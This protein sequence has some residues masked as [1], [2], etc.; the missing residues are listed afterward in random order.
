MPIGL[1]EELRA[2]R[3]LRHLSLQ[4]V[5]TPANISV[6][7]L[8]KLEGGLV[9]SPSPRVLHRLSRVLDISYERLMD[10]AGYHVPGQAQ[11]SSSMPS[12]MDDLNKAEWKAVTAFVHYLKAQRDRTAE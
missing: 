12:A 1:G 5:A 9:N 4:D 8:Q 2:G 6:A 7:Y 10:L 11:G 3:K